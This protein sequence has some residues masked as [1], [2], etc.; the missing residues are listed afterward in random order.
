MAQRHRQGAR[1]PGDMAL[2]RLVI[3]PQAAQI[4]GDEVRRVL[5]DNDEI[6][7]PRRVG[8][9]NGSVPRWIICFG[10]D[11]LGQVS[12]PVNLSISFQFTAIIKPYYD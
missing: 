12:L 8:Y 2:Q 7:P 1:V 10:A 5:T 9:L 3:Q 6:T 4:G 11:R